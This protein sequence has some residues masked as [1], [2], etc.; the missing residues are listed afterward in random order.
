LKSEKQEAHVWKRLTTG[1]VSDLGIEAEVGHG[2]TH[3]YVSDNQI[4][5]TGASDL[6]R[7]RQLQVLDLGDIVTE[8]SQV[9]PSGHELSPATITLPRPECLTPI[10]EQG[11]DNLTYLRIDHAIVTEMSSSIKKAKAFEIEDSSELVLP[12][13]VAELEVSSIKPR[14]LS[15]N[16]IHEA[17][18]TIPIYAEL[19]GS[20]VTAGPS[21][22]MVASPRDD[23]A[24]PS[25]TGQEDSPQPVPA[26][27]PV[28]DSSG[29]LFS[30]VSPLIPR[31]VSHG[32][33]AISS[34]HLTVPGMTSLPEVV[35][36]DD[37][38]VDDRSEDRRH[39]SRLRSYSGVLGDH[40]ARTRFRQSQDHHLLAATLGE[41]CTLVLTNVP[42]KSSSPDTA[43]RIINFIKDCAEEEHWATLKASVGYQLPPGPDRRS[44]ELYYARTI[45]PFRKLVLEMAPEL[46]R[47]SIAGNR[48][49]LGRAGSVVSNM[50]S[51]TLDP[52]CETYLNAAKD[53]FSF[54][55]SEECGLPDTEGTAPVPLVAL[56]EKM[57][58]EPYPANHITDEGNST[59]QEQIYDV[60][61]EVS[62]FRR[63]KK[64]DYE[65]ASARG[66][67]H[68]DGHW[69][70]VIEVVRP[71]A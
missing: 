68:V 61:A 30:P 11:G 57:S 32:A 4:T 69:S 22:P 5:F 18:G 20:P 62:R 3:L 1:F 43:A 21:R 25:A 66:E 52:D 42:T 48:R 9:H 67:N 2:I 53:D 41:I 47:S 36:S 63:S 24:V 7:C 65:V 8:L 37:L 35:A 45:F 56:Q 13:N 16:P 71:R 31:S 28:V 19:E 29:G 39:Q 51:S 59:P 40:E 60:L 33:N 6:L 64:A 44:A 46:S 50:L 54:F 55:A 12:R 10:I 27:D 26:L 23:N 34:W 14:E 58:I 70:G 17:V 15:G 49:S 38:E